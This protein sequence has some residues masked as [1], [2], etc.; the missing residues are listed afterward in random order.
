MG[1]LAAVARDF[2]PVGT[3]TVPLYT[4]RGLTAASENQAVKEDIHVLA[5]LAN[6][7]QLKNGLNLPPFVTLEAFH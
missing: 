7:I 5:L 4:L 3:H 2:L 1:W 6:Q